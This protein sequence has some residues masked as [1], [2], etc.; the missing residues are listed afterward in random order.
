MS[1]HRSHTIAAFLD[2]AGAPFRG[3]PRR[4]YPDPEIFD[5]EAF[6]AD[7]RGIEQVHAR[8]LAAGLV[9]G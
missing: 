7:V 5:R 6:D 3:A 4:R 1:A 2:I 8:L 9:E